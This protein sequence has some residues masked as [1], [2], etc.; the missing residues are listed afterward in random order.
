MLLFIINILTMNIY[1]YYFI[2]DRLLY[3]I[4]CNAHIYF[5]YNSYFV[6][7]YFINLIS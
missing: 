3:K 6:Y 2:H 1:F 5:S 7:I 4:M